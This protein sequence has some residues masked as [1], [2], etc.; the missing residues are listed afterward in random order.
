MEQVTVNIQQ[1]DVL[2]VKP[3]TYGVMRKVKVVRIIKPGVEYGCVDVGTKEF[4]KVLQKDVLSVNADQNAA[5]R[6]DPFS[7]SQPAVKTNTDSIDL[8]NPDTWFT[9]DRS[10]FILNEDK[11]S[12]GDDSDEEND[13]KPEDPENGNPEE[14]E[15]EDE[16]EAKPEPGEGD[17]PSEDGESG[18]DAEGEQQE[19]EGDKGEGNGGEAEAQQGSPSDADMTEQ[20]QETDE[21]VEGNGETGERGKSIA[22][23]EHDHNLTADTIRV[24][25]KKRF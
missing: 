12:G 5:S 10:Y 20:G 18:G 23:P 11:D 25:K 13:S 1:E 6:R 8:S 7:M 21:I 24:T 3:N 17:E 15:G 9:V 16:G 2:T 14:E 22:A 4:C 19:G